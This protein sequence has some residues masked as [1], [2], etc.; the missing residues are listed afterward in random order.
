M[1]SEAEGIRNK[2]Q[3]GADGSRVLLGLLITGNRG[4][5][6]QQLNG[7]TLQQLNSLM[8]WAQELSDIAYKT[9]VE[10]T[11]DL[12]AVQGPTP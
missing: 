2:I 7:M 6:R 3:F 9:W 5:A 1:T 8:N 4:K 11:N 12:R 10:K